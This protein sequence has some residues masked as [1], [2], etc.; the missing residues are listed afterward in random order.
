M[1][2]SDARQA[3][4]GSVEFLLVVPL[5]LVLMLGALQ[6]SLL[7]RGKLTANLAT[8]E[9]ARSGAVNHASFESVRNGFSRSIA[10]L[11][12][13]AGQ[14]A[15]AL[16]SGSTFEQLIGDGTGVSRAELVDEGRNRVPWGD[17]SSGAGINGSSF[18]CA[19]RLNPP[20]EAFGAFGGESDGIPNDNLI[21]R[22]PPAIAV[23]APPAGPD[24]VVPPAGEL[25]LQDANLLHIRI[26][27]CHPMI[28]PV[29]STLIKNVMLFVDGDPTAGEN[30][31]SS[32]RRRC[33]QAQELGLDLY[34][35]FPLTTESIVRMQSNAV[36]DPEFRVDCAS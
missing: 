19:E 2:R 9:A 1:K 12:V 14:L 18:I 34:P 11:Y 5:V 7:Y 20:E 36:V 16:A 27:Y 10:A 4:Q 15:P 24:G 6:F 3:G 28:V 32:F 13:N 17:L 35:R 23:S 26:T 29:A 33:L 25:T 22:N 31:T 30:P 21:F 8:F